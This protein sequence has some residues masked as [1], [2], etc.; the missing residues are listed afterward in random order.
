M[1]RLSF[2]SACEMGFRGS[3]GEWRLMG[4]VANSEKSGAWISDTG[5]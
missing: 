4:A 2:D 1:A 3:L 5:T